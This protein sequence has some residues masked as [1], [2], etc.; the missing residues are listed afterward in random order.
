MMHSIRLVKKFWLIRLGM[1]AGLMT[2]VSLG[3]GQTDIPKSI[4]EL[5]TKHTCY[6]CHKTDVKLVGPS[7]TAISAKGM[8][9]AEFVQSV[10][11]P[12][13][14]KWP[15]FPPMMP[16]P[17]VPKKDLEKIADWVLKLKPAAVK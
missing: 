6:T 9:K 7:W 14:T 4:N 10:Y 16:M 11:Q 12:D 15:G 8:K 1:V 17:Q 3:F 2:C 13:A 5:L